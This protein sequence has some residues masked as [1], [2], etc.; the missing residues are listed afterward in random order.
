MGDEI[1]LSKPYG[2]D[3]DKDFRDWLQSLNLKPRDASIGARSWE[4]VTYNSSVDQRTRN[5]N[6]YYWSRRYQHHY[7]MKRMK[8]RTDLLRKHLPNAGIGAN[9]SPLP[10]H[11][12][13][14]E[15]HKWVTTFVPRQ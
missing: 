12:Y 2:T 3:L 6:S 4:E 7:G 9:Y 15:V 14:G 13:L 11:R 1:S 5:S 8:E 10:L